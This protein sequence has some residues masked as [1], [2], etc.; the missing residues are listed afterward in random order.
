[1]YAFVFISINTTDYLEEHHS[2]EINERDV[3]KEVKLIVFGCTCFEFDKG[4]QVFD[5]VHFSLTISIPYAM[6]SCD[7][8]SSHRLMPGKEGPLK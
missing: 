3:G 2:F 6:Y 1:M 4:Q 7:L 8:I 5:H